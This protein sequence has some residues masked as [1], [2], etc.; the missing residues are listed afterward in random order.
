MTAKTKL[1]TNQEKV[2]KAIKSFLNKNGKAPTFT[3]LREELLKQKMELKSNNSIVQYLDA[4]ENKGYIQKF[5]KARGIRVLEESLDN[6]VAIPLLGQ[7]NCGEPLSFAS[8]I[9]EDYINISKK[10]IKDVKEKY[11][12]LKASGDSMNKADI[13]NGDLVLVKKTDNPP[14]DNKIVV[15]TINGLGTIKKFKKTKKNP[16]LMPES[17]NSKHQP[18]LLHEDDDINIVG[19]VMEVF[20]MSFMENSY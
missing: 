11:F 12:F 19:E 4:L 15:A 20:S 13:N 6:F 8:D 14:V 18:I 3:E 9:I 1:T 5:N 16:V 7:A 10:Y 2:L 17:T